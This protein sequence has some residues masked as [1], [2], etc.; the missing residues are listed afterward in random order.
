MKEAGK[1]TLTPRIES[2][3]DGGAKPQE[4]ERAAGRMRSKR[5]A[6]RMWYQTRHGSAAVGAAREQADGGTNM[7]AG[8]TGEQ[9]DGWA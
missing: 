4:S 9:A 8:V 2:S 3:L 7:A 6:L 1:G 5:T